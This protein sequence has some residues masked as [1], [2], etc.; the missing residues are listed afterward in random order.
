MNGSPVKV[1][2]LVNDW[3]S[4]CHVCNLRTQQPSKRVKLP[5]RQ[6]RTIGQ[7]ANTLADDV[8]LEFGKVAKRHASAPY[9]ALPFV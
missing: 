7:C 9:A 1:N 8:V 3:P 6:K 2:R 5:V 4:V